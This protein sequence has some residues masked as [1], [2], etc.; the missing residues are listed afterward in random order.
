MSDKQLSALAGAVMV[1]GA[2]IA[3][4]IIVS[5]VL[6]HL[7]GANAMMALALL[8]LIPTTLGLIVFL[9]VLNKQAT[10]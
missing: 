6:A 8:A 4:A 1:V 9:A 2:F 7:P 10:R 5:G 3:G